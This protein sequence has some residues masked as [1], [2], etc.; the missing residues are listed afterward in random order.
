MILFSK[1]ILKKLKEAELMIEPFTSSQ[2]QPAS[3]DLLDTVAISK[4]I[5]D[6]YL[7]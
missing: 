5:M 3:I 1:T 4:M 6:S 2:V 7:F